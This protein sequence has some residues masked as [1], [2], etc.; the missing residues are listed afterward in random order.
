MTHAQTQHS[1]PNKADFPA[2]ACPHCERS[3]KP[4]SVNGD[5]SVTYTCV[6]ANHLATHG[7]PMTWR[8]TRDGSFVE[9]DQYTGRYSSH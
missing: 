1:K 6:A 8:I 4:R 9:K 7:L 3:T 5:L 2:L